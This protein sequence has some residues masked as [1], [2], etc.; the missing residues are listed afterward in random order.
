MTTYKEAGVDIDVANTGLSKIK[1]HIN[2]TYN[3]YNR[4][5]NHYECL[6]YGGIIK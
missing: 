3:K 6:K 4:S 2:N 1:K 5:C